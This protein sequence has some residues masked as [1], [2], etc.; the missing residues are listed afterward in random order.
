MP[1]QTTLTAWR[2][3]T[4]PECENKCCTWSGTTVCFP[5]AQRLLGKAELIARYNKTHDITWAEATALDA[6]ERKVP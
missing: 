4:T 6:A 2:N 5:C 3:C 1:Y